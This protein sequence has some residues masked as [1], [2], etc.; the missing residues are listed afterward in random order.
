MINYHY[1]VGSW[2]FYPIIFVRLVLRVRFRF[3]LKPTPNTSANPHHEKVLPCRHPCHTWELGL[4]D[5]FWSANKSQVPRSQLLRL[6]RLTSSGLDLGL[7]DSCEPAQYLPHCKMLVFMIYLTM[8]FARWCILNF[9]LNGAVE[10]TTRI[11]NVVS[12]I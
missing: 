12:V 4:G 8:S 1:S 2:L 10:L 3:L 7:K 6:Y 5:P 11:N 9:L